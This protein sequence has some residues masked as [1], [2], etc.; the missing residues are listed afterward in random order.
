MRNLDIINIIVIL[1]IVMI[2]LV[3]LFSFSGSVKIVFE[4]E[5]KINNLN[6]KIDDLQ[7]ELDEH[8]CPK[9]ICKNTSSGMFWSVLGG[10]L[11][12]SGLIFWWYKSADLSKREKILKEKED[13]FDNNRYI[14][15]LEKK[16]K[17]LQKK[18]KKKK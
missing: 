11:Y 15:S 12:I 13:M 7:K 16:L 8:E 1:T 18:A 10:I 2:P 5:Q 6:D 14:E 17:I 3:A 4:Q 9:V